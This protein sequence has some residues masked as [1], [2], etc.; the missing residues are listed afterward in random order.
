MTATS[1]PLKVGVQVLYDGEVAEIVELNG[2]QVTARI[3][4]TGRFVTV[5]IA[6]FAAQCRS[7]TWAPDRMPSSVGT[8]LALLDGAERQRLDERVLHIRELLDSPGPMRRREETK[9]A[10]LGVTPRTIRRWV[11]DY[12]ELGE[13]GLI[14]HRKAPVRTHR[15]DPRWEA[16]VLE[17]LEGHVSGSNLTRKAV[18]AE[19]EQ[20]LVARFGAGE[21]QIPPGTTAYRRLVQISKGT[22]AFTGS[23]SGRRSIA[24]RPKGVYGRLRAMRPGEILVLDTQHLDVF[25]MEPVTCRWLG[26]QL[27]VAQDLFSR[28]IVGMRVTPASTKSVDVAAVLFEAIAG[29]T[30]PESWP[31]EANWPY[32]GLPA[33]VVLDQ[34]D[35]SAGPVCA[36]ESVVIDNGKIY[37]SR[38]VLAVCE[39]L[40]ISVQPAQP[41]KPTDKPTVERFFRTLRQGL[42]ERLPAY[43]GPDVHSR[44]TAVENEAFFYLHELEDLIRE[45]AATVYHRSKHDG[46]CIPQAPKQELSPAE[47]YAIGIGKAGLL[48]LPAAPELAMDFLPVA[49]RTIQHYGVEVNGLRYNGAALDP[50]RGT[51]SPFGGALAGKWPIHF[52]PDDVRW[53]W[54]EDPEGGRFHRLEWEHAA[55]LGTALSAEAAQHARRIALTQSHAIVPEKA[56]AELLDRWSTG[57]VNDRRERRMAARLS[58]EYAAL[59]IQEPAPVP[60]EPVTRPAEPPVFSDEDEEDG[61]DEGFYDGAFEVLT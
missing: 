5:S 32:H 1:M 11:A 31:E 17:V 59:P 22:N 35:Q 42:I 34:G 27:T 41:F 14:D 15:V 54:F 16:A 55:M 23:A 53:V 26:V 52:H 57:L 50:Y 8:A 7:T 12:Q 3:V 39:R 36:P 56:V 10:E 19:V 6:Q 21:V 9:A 18:L 25:A 28:C 4:R 46:L 61:F 45:W 49:A 48:R 60:A 51:K 13:A 33:R 20:L 44:G 58:A 43:K 30:P 2:A 24:D 38:H 29:R 40:G 47:M 37:I